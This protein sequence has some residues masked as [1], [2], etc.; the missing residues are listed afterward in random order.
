LLENCLSLGI[1]ELNDVFF[2]TTVAKLICIDPLDELNTLVSF[3]C[4]VLAKK[5]EREISLL[6]YVSLIIS[7][8]QGTLTLL[9]DDLVALIIDFTSDS[10][11][12]V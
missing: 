6:F 2:A 11:L 9:N 5:F 7:G 8:R 10:W 12:I 4:S 3:L 1:E